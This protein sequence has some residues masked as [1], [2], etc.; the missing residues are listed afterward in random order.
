MDNILL[1]GAQVDISL[2][3]FGITETAFFIA[4]FLFGAA[5]AGYVVGRR[6]SQGHR[7]SDQDAAHGVGDTTLGA[8]LALLGLLLAFSFGNALSLAETRKGDVIIE[9]NAIGTAFARADFL[10]EPGRTDLK[11]ALLAYGETRLWPEA[12]DIGNQ[13]EALQFLNTTLNAQSRLWPIILENADDPVPPAIQTFVASSVNDILDAHQIRMRSVA[14]PVAELSQTIVVL[15]AIAGLFVLGNRS[16]LSGRPLTWRTF[17]FSSLL[18]A[19][20]VT[21]IDLQRASDGLLRVDQSPLLTT[22][23][24]MTRQLEQDATTSIRKGAS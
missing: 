22:I 5:Y 12:S 7:S 18:F 9:A 21:V 24:Q 4:F 1:P 19:V 8:I 23:A 2:P 17:L 20:I 11:Q 6:R 14:T 16:A 10:P 15:T 3:M 13:E